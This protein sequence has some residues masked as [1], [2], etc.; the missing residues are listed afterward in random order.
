MGVGRPRSR[1]HYGWGWQRRGAE[2]VARGAQ[3]RKRFVTP[4]TNCRARKSFADSLPSDQ[5]GDTGSRRDSGTRRRGH[6]WII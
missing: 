1:A 6:T 3:G 5:R 4:P 2:G